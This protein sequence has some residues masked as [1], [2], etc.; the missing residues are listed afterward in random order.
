MRCLTY[1]GFALTSYMCTEDDTTVCLYLGTFSPHHGHEDIDLRT[2]EGSVI[3]ISDPDLFWRQNIRDVQMLVM[4]KKGRCCQA[5]TFTMWLGHPVLTYTFTKPYQFPS[6]TW[7]GLLWSIS[8]LSF[9]CLVLANPKEEV[10]FIHCSLPFLHLAW[11]PARTRVRLPAQEVH[12]TLWEVLLVSIL[13][14]S[15]TPD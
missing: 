3:G 5:L 6:S 7:K 14:S 10:L 15:M 4:R 1:C 9:Q 12:F 8:A 11:G 13:S 2:F